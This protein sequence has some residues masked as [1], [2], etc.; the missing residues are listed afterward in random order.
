V[1]VFATDAPPKR[2]TTICP[3]SKSAKPPMYQ[4]FHTDCH[5]TQSLMKTRAPQGVN[6]GQNIQ[7]CQLKFF[8]CSQHKFF[9]L[10]S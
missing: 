9:S 6:K 10:I 3:L 1:A 5:S 4:F 8:Q 7:C 2:A